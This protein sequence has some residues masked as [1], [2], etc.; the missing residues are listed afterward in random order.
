MTLQD[1]WCWLPSLPDAVCL[2]WMRLSDPRPGEETFEFLYFL[3]FLYFSLGFQE[4]VFCILRP[5]RGWGIWQFG[6]QHF[7]CHCFTCSHLVINCYIFVISMVF[8]TKRKSTILSF[9]IVVKS[10]HIHLQPC[11]R[12]GS[13]VDGF[14]LFFFKNFFTFFIVLFYLQSCARHRSWVDCGAGG[15]LWQ[16]RPHH[17]HVVRDQQRHL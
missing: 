16:V 5:C 17:V 2:V 12:H 13:W 9:N 8:D 10:S 1:W 14:F 3:F 4:N 11:A 7:N 15:G 6:V